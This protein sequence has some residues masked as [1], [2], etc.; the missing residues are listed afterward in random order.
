[1]TTPHAAGAS[2]PSGAGIGKENSPLDTELCRPRTGGI[3]GGRSGRRHHLAVRRELGF[4]ENLKLPADTMVRLEEMATGAHHLAVSGKGAPRRFDCL[5]SGAGGALHGRRPAVRRF[6]QRVAG[7]G[8]PEA[9]RSAVQAIH[10]DSALRQSRRLATR[11][12]AER[13]DWR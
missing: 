12:T 6:D 4:R 5:R 11:A 2:Q 10:N 1:M 7:R 3:A 9:F 8:Q 13:Y